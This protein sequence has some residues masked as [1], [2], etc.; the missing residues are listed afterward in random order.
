MQVGRACEG[1]YLLSPSGVAI[2]RSKSVPSPSLESVMISRFTSKTDREDPSNVIGVVA[3]CDLNLKKIEDD[4]LLSALAASKSST[5]FAVVMRQRRATAEAWSRPLKYL[6]YSETT[7]CDNSA[8]FRQIEFSKIL[9]TSRGQATISYGWCKLLLFL[10]SLKSSFSTTARSRG[11]RLLSEIMQNRHRLV[12]FE[13]G[14][15][16]VEARVEESYNE[17]A[18]RGLMMVLMA[19]RGRLM[20]S[21]REEEGDRR[22][23]EKSEDDQAR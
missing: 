19:W 18:E 13:W 11:R 5:S 9:S 4:I 15:R 20:E 6:L 14:E 21:W 7:V 23:C 12:G 1:I 22:L 3:F 8:V 17:R 16:I 2:L 10:S